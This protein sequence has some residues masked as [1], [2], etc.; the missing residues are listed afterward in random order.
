M[1]VA[2]QD[3]LDD[4]QEM[5]EIPKL[6]VTKQ[7]L[8]YLNSDLE[9]D[10]QRLDEANQVLLRKIQEKEEAI[11][12]LEGEIALSLARA[13]EREELN[14]IASEKEETLRNLESETAKLEKSNKILSRNVV[15]LQ[16]KISRRH[17][18]DGL[19]KETLKQMLAELKVRLQKSTES[20]T[21]Q[22][23]ELLKIES[24]YQSLHQLC[25]DQAHYI[26]KYQEILRQMEKEKEVML[27][28]KEVFKAQ[29]NSS[30][31]V[32]PGSILVE[33]I[34][35]NMEKTI[36]KKQKRIF[37]YRHFRCLVFMVMIFIRL[38]GYALFHL[39]YINPDLLV[40]ALPMVMSRDT[41]KRLREVLFP[42]LTLEVEEVL[43][44]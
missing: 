36:I 13:N 18:N 7:N 35:S 17:K 22:E 24:D 33:T 30:Q 11:Q 4:V 27:L 41:L 9:K 8:D 42:F 25:E 16:K 29:N 43:P 15:E 23:K 44:H 40:D 14:H 5:M 1:E 20:C 3:P 12:S 21:K 38:L 19:N 2:G 32:K 6:E 34:Q 39:Q 10:L 31:I 37:W 28:E 26:K